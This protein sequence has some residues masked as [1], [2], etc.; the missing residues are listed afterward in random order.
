MYGE[1]LC[2]RHRAGGLGPRVTTEVWLVSPADG[3]EG[4][5]VSEE[6]VAQ[7]Q[8]PEPHRTGGTGGRTLGRRQ[9]QPSALIYFLLWFSSSG[10][11]AGGNAVSQP[12]VN[13]QALLDI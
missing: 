10:F 3:G 12:K 13:E 11:E 1:P 4:S 5:T 2:D 6:R 7:S 8:T 9:E